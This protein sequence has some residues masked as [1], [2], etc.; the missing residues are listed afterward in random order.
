MGLNMTQRLGIGR[1]SEPNVKMKQ[2]GVTGADMSQAFVCELLI[3]N[4]SA[5]KRAKLGL[6]GTGW[7]K[8]AGGR[9]EM[10]SYNGVD[11]KQPR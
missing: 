8:S 1:E 10:N 5:Q 11:E 9:W 3:F 4:T 7:H 2:R 6:S